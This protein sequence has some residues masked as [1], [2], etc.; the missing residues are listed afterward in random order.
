MKKF[1]LLA[2][3]A[4]AAGTSAFAGPNTKSARISDH[5][6]S[7]F[8]NAQNVT[9]TTAEKY[10]QASF[11]VGAQKVDAY[12]DTD[13]ELIGTIRGMDFDKLP[14]SAI[15]TITTKYTFPE[16]R[17]TDCIEFT[18]RA[19]NTSYFVSFQNKKDTVVYEISK[20]GRLKYFATR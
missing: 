20:N 12:Y 19:S 16:Y 3:T 1:F 5:F 14:Q 9:W 15:E 10:D 11:T 8:K 4:I 18:D 13:G 17:L 7:A 2:L 6:S